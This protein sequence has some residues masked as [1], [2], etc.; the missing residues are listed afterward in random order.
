MARYVIMSR[1]SPEALK[2]PADLRTPAERVCGEI[3]T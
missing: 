3:K 2:E 1:I